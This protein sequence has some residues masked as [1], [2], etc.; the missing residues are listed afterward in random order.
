MTPGS[1][2]GVQGGGISAGVG[3]NDVAL[4]FCRLESVGDVESSFL[5]TGGERDDTRWS[6]SSCPRG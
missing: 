5:M 4:W 3:V 2:Q 6:W 1:V